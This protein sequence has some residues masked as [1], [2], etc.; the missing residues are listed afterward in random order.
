MV[1]N[2]KKVICRKILTLENVGNVGELAWYFYNI[3]PWR[4]YFQAPSLPD[5]R[6]PA[7]RLERGTAGQQTDGTGVNFNK[8]FS[9]TVKGEEIR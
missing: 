1:A 9:A 7:G 6:R 5:D 8:L 4:H 2:L 3:G